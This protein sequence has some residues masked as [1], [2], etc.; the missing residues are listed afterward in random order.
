[1]RRSVTC[2]EVSLLTVC[3]SN[4]PSWGLMVSA[5]SPSARSFLPCIPFRHWLLTLTVTSRREG[6]QRRSRSHASVCGARGG[7]PCGRSVAGC[8]MGSRA[9]GARYFLFLVRGIAELRG[10][11]GRRLRIDRIDRSTMIATHKI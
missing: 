1:M 8:L 5:T 7:P 11:I 4:G 6:N 9:F 3:P 10:T 2:V